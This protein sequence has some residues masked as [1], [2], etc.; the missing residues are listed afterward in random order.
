MES[1]FNLKRHGILVNETRGPISF[2]ITVSVSFGPSLVVGSLVFD[3]IPSANR[4]NSFL[5]TYM[6]P[7]LLW[8]DWACKVWGETVEGC[9]GGRI[10]AKERE[11]NC[12]SSI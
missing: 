9:F 3:T 5:S 11:K 10:G 1:G 7:S 8:H 6:K 4:E 12:A 2:R